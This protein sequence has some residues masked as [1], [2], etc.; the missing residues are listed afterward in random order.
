MS[1][2]TSPRNHRPVGAGPAPSRARTPRSA[3]ALLLLTCLAACKSPDP[4]VEMELLDLETY[5][6]VDP[7]IGQTNYLA[8]AIRFRL[9]NRGSR[10]Q[11]S[12]QATA[13]FRRKGEES[14]TWGSD[15]QQVAGVKKPLPVGETTVV[16]LKSDA[17]YTSPGPA[18]EMLGNAQFK[19]AKAEVFVRVGSSG[20]V[21]FA[22][23]DVERR[24]GSRTVQ[25]FQ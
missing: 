10:P 7:S 18:A 25:G 4:K 17:R 1:E 12:V 20:W 6:A 5:W 19:D 2:E 16:V 21:K 15:W 9:R 22:D 3:L 24:I 8:P 14:L 11:R 23:A 13:V